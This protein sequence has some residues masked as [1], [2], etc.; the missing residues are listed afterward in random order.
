MEVR[1]NL[2]ILEG[3][4][5]KTAA[6]FTLHMLGKYAIGEKIVERYAFGREGRIVDPALSTIVAG[7]DFENPV[8]VAAGWDKK[9]W[10]VKGLYD[11]GFGGVEVGTVP[12]FGQYGN[13]K[14]RLWTIN[15][16]HS[17]G[18]NRLGFNSIGAE[19]VGRNLEATGKLPCPVGVNIGLNKLMPADKAAWAHAEV[20]KWIYPFASYVVLGVSS[21]NTEQV[22]GLQAKG[23]LTDITIAT[24][25]A[26]SAEGGVK[27]LFYKIDGDRSLEEIH[28]IIE[29]AIEQKAAGIIAINTT[30]NQRIKAK[31][32]ERWANMMGGL[33]GADYEYQMRAN[34]VVRHIYEQAGD[35]LEIIGVGGINTVLAA[36]NRIKSGASA[37]QVLTAMVEHRGRIASKISKG[38]QLV[39]AQEGI[40]N[41]QEL[42]GVRTNRGQKVLLSDIT[43]Y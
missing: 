25:D 23:P 6:E 20:V 17:V 40:S 18:F 8:L 14:P 3:E 38:L 22:R 2:E 7:I 19:R 28:D 27:P 33:S 41:I 13:D 35:K 4:G 30:T 1:K 32:G 16:T 31:Y 10:A 15:S 43:A 39:V 29:V 26:M 5:L 21:P 34:E 24:N 37:V 42:I 12:L 11:L 9:G 36:V